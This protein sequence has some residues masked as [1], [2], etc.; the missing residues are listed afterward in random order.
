LEDF[1][2]QPSA[3]RRILQGYGYTLFR[4]THDKRGPVV[5]RIDSS[6]SPE[7]GGEPDFIATLE[8]SRLCER[9]ESRDWHVMRLRPSRG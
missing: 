1:G 3:A 4:L 6:S 2:E 9:F 5:W 8:P 7:P